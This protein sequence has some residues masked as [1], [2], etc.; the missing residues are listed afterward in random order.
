MRRSGERDH[1]RS[2]YFRAGATGG[3]SVER[4]DLFD[5]MFD[6]F[7]RGYSTA[8]LLYANLTL[9]FFLASFVLPENFR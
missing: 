5:R 9:S 4:I 3:L 7:L 2:A 6:A 8:N 1:G